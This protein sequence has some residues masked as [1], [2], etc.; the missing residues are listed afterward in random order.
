MTDSHTI[1]NI[2]Y[3][4]AAHPEP[5]EEERAARPELNVINCY[6]YPNDRYLI[7]AHPELVEGE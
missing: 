4:I 7:A 6:I 2:R 1:T 3:L 5:V